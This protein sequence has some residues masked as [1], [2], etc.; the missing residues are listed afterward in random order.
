MMFTQVQATWLTTQFNFVSY[1]YLLKIEK[2]YSQS[3]LILSYMKHQIT[4]CYCEYQITLYWLRVNLTTHLW[5]FTVQKSSTSPT[6][7]HFQQ[8]YLQNPTISQPFHNISNTTRVN[9]FWSQIS[10]YS[11]KTSTSSKHTKIY[12]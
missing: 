1:G 12:R 5:Y 3:A 11:L 2:T 6:S 10:V 9:I 8:Y 7:Q 4:Y